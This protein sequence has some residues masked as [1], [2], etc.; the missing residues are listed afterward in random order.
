M[1]VVDS[2]GDATGVSA[3]PPGGFPASLY[4]WPTGISRIPLTGGSRAISDP[5]NRCRSALARE[6]VDQQHLPAVAPD[7]VGA[8]DL[9]RAIVGSLDQDVRAD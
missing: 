7:D 2:P 4:F 9:I 1:Q 5:C 3:S 6:Q 8:D